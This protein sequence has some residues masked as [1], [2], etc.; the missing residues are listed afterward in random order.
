MKT[1][2]KTSKRCKWDKDWSVHECGNAHSGM[3]GKLNCRQ[4]NN[5]GYI[6]T[7]P[8]HPRNKD[9]YDF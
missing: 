9:P 3:F 1:G 2:R 8:R 4:C 6:C 7:S 5:T